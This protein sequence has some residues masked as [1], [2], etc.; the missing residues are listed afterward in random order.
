MKILRN[1]Q[2]AILCCTSLAFFITLSACTP[3]KATPKATTEPSSTQTP[4]TGATQTK[5][6]YPKNTVSNPTEPPK[7]TPTPTP[8]LRMRY[9]VWQTWPIYP[10][11]SPEML[12]VFQRGQESGRDEHAFSVIG[13]CQSSPT[14]FLSL[15]DESRYSLPE[16]EAFLE[17]T[18]EWYAGSFSH[19]SITVANGLSAPGALNPRWSD[20]S[21]CRKN[22]KP[23]DCEIR[24]HNPS[25]VLISLG[26]N[27]H[28]SLSHEAYLEYL[29]QIIETLL[30]EDIIPIISTK[31]DNVEGDYGRNLAMA[32]AAYE[33]Q[34]PLWNFWATVQ[35]L[36]NNG[37]DKTRNDEYL[38]YKG[39]DVRNLSALRLLAHIHTQLNNSED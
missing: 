10:E 27:W 16:D 14:Y 29:Y 4:T 30:E 19:R 22:E 39:W 33:Y 36:P 31:A 8:D 7:G 3:S 1:L 18:I 34:L 32:Q 28:P 11:L 17:E 25:I 13:D 20:P 26:T 24:L 9:E 6:P 35:H 12:A 21:K 5:T 15:Y 2:Q 37:L 38:T 23:I